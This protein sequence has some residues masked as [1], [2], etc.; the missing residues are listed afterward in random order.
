MARTRS[1]PKRGW[2]VLTG[3][4]KRDFNK[5]KRAMQAG[6]IDRYKNFVL[7]PSMLPQYKVPEFP[8]GFALKPYV[9]R[10]A[11]K[12]GEERRRK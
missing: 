4:Q 8:L 3:K 1:V 10:T 6:F 7:V 5:G 9:A 12:E 2:K 11:P